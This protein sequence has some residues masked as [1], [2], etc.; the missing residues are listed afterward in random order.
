MR[1]K[2][3]C[4]KAGVFSIGP[5]STGLQG[6]VVETQNAAV[7]HGVQKVALWSCAPESLPEAKP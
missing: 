4:F 2:Q 5:T 1:L 6:P 3:G 7:A